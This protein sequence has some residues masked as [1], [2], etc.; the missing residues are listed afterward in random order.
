M[1]KYFLLIFFLF[2]L[3]LNAQELF[4]SNY[5][6]T[7]A[8]INHELLEACRGDYRKIGN[9]NKRNK[10]LSE[11][12]YKVF[13]K[14]FRKEKDKGYENHQI[15]LREYAINAQKM[16]KLLKDLEKK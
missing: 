6:S 10:K 7:Q 9:A 1:K 13:I 15:L 5:D 4:M 14:A 3:N 16:K 12:D 8:G 2:S 11:A